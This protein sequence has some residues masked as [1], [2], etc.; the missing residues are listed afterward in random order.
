M[1]NDT[2]I[3]DLTDEPLAFGARLLAD[4]GAEVIRVEDARADHLRMREPAMDGDAPRH[5]RGWAH[6]LYNGGKRSV[7]VDM[8][9]IRPPG[10]GLRRCCRT[11]DAVL[12]PLE[13]SG[14]LAAWLDRG[15][16]SGWS[17]EI[18]IVDAV[19]RRG[20]DEPMSDITTMAAGGHVVLNGHPEDPP[21]WPGGQP[22]AQAGINRDG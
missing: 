7:A 13:S 4:L 15:R 10:A 16:N 12:A 22:L 17:S 3:L 9:T 14:E 8:S 1:L 18:P 11:F 5:E 2:R 6:L 20:A 21:V 19:F